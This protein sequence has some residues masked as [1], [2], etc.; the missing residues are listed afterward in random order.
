MDNSSSTFPSS[1]ITHFSRYTLNF[2][3]IALICGNEM[4][5]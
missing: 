2:K 1:Q 3:A 4:L 5:L